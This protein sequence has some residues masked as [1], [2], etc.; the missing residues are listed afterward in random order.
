[1]AKRLVTA[2][3]AEFDTLADDW[4]QALDEASAALDASGRAYPAAELRRIDVC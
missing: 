2:A 4:Q 1:M 3:N